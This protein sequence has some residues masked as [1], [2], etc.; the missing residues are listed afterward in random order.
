MSNEEIITEARS[1]LET[2]FHHQGRVRGVGVDCIGLIVEVARALKLPSA[3]GG[4]VADYDERDYPREPDGERLQMMLGRHFIQDEREKSNEGNNF[5]PRRSQRFRLPHEGGVTNDVRIGLFRMRHQ[6]QHVGLV[7]SE[8]CAVGSEKSFPGAVIPGPDAQYQD[9][10][11]DPGNK[12]ID[13]IPNQVGN[14]EPNIRLIHAYL[15]AGKVVETHFDA[16]WQ[17]RLVGVYEFR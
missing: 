4:L 17:R 10:T 3:S 8:Q 13:W 2:P 14:D 1:W 16:S 9:P 12:K 11:R 6:P 7:F 5:P 15:P